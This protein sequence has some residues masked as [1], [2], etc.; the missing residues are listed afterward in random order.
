MASTSVKLAVGE[1]PTHVSPA[2]A[3]AW[4]AR[5]ALLIARLK[6]RIAEFGD[7]L[8]FSVQGKEIPLFLPGI[9]E[10]Y[11]GN[12]MGEFAFSINEFHGSDRR[13]ATL[14]FYDPPNLFQKLS[15]SERQE[16]RAVVLP[17]DEI[18]LISGTSV[19]LKI[20][21]RKSELR[22]GPDGLVGA[23]PY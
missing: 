4:P 6:H 12:H 16:R 9:L 20:E 2:D 22:L 13:V 10:G 3:K 7:R 19:Q 18:R 5:Q 15:K 21:L 14:R 17:L 8:T 11:R 23:G 1:F